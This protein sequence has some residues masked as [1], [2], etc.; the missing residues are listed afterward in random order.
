MKVEQ[1]TTQAMHTRRMPS[2]DAAART[3]PPSPK[4]GFDPSPLHLSA[5]AAF[6]QDTRMAGGAVPSV[7]QDVVAEVRA[8]LD[9]GTFERTVD[10]EAAIDG[11]LADL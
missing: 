1:G 10:W 6:V 8:A 7:R 2:A 5:A 9:A 11:L 3:P 4:G